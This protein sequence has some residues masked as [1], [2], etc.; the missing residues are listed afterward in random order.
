MFGCQCWIKP[1]WE[2]DD[3]GVARPQQ[4]ADSE[5]D[6]LLGRSNEQ[7]AR[8]DGAV[9]RRCDGLPQSLHATSAC[10]SR[11]YGIRLYDINLLFVVGCLRAVHIE[12]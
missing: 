11:M 2:G 4:C 9:L 6:E 3:A 12:Q 8:R 5:V 7:L 10:Q 1:T